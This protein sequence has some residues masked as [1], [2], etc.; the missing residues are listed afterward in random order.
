MKKTS[1]NFEPFLSPLSRLALSGIFVTSG[2]AKFKEF[3]NNVQYAKSKN[4]PFVK[5]AIAFA[6]AIEVAGGLS[7][8]FGYKSKFM[9]GAL[10]AYLIPVSAVFHDF[11][12]VEGQEKQMQQINFM[13]NLAI[14][15]GLLKYASHGSGSLSLDK[16]LESQDWPL[17]DRFRSRFQSERP[18]VMK[19]AEKIPSRTQAK[20]LPKGTTTRSGQ[21]LRH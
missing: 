7:L 20:R 10:A 9:S 11:W 16:S 13:K 17:I 8:L 18:W 14:I 6:G 19:I 5:A 12:K 4:L 15:G 1:R 21:V 2:L 3:E